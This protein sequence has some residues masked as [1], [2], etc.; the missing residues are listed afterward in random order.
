[1]RLAS[2]IAIDPQESE[3]LNTLLGLPTHHPSLT[4]PMLWLGKG[5]VPDHIRA[6]VGADH[7]ALQE[8]QEFY[9]HRPLPQSGSLS[10]HITVHTE[11]SADQNRLLL[12]ASFN[13][14]DQHSI[15]TLK[16]T[17]RIVPKPSTPPAAQTSSA[18]PRSQTVIEQSL[19]P[20][21]Q[22][23]INHYAALS[24]DTNPVH[25]DEQ[26]ARMLGLPAPIAH[27][28]LLMGLTQSG[29]AAHKVSLPAEEHAYYPLRFACRFLLPVPA[30]QICGLNRKQQ[31]VE[32]RL[33][34]RITLLSEAGP[35][36]LAQLHYQLAER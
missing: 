22:A 10:A 33:S 5:A 34:E 8:A 17:L 6:M 23:L 27:G 25:L 24:G 31:S 26:A 12:E 9:Y 14:Q 28:M 35:H 7:M 16:T 15:L 1:M 30:G 3:A 20:I 19:P 13:D 11:D 21:T 18:K 4:L 2:S 32:G 36:V 29:M